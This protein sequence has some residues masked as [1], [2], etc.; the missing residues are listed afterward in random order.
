MSCS[1]EDI[2]I[3]WMYSG[4]RKK[5]MLRNCFLK[6]KRSYFISL[7]KQNA[8]QKVCILSATTNSGIVIKT[9]G[10]EGL[11][12]N[13]R[14]HKNVLEWDDDIGGT[15]GVHTKFNI[16]NTVC[17]PLTIVTAVYCRYKFVFLLDVSPSVMAVDFES[18]NIVYEQIF[19]ALE[20]CF[21]AL[22]EPL[23]FP[24]FKV[25]WLFLL[26]LSLSLKQIGSKLAA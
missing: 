16:F 23:I 15:C 25:S 21:L 13:S 10:G 4:A 6:F 17:N 9:F 5:S 24:G 1:Y 8:D 18:G 11:L 14:F 3:S 20:H 26:S 2:I 22:V 12:L 7:L 19:L